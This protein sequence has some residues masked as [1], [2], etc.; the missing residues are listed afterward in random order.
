M[1]TISLKPENL[2]HHRPSLL[3]FCFSMLIT[4]EINMIYHTYFNA[5]IILPFL[6][7]GGMDFNER[8]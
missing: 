8:K 6:Y 7:N 5:V 1:T 3:R 2:I 4:G